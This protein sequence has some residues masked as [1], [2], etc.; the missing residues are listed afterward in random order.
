M[1]GYQRRLPVLDMRRQLAVTRASGKRRTRRQNR[2][3]GRRDRRQTD[4]LSTM[5]NGDARATDDGAARQL[6]ASRT[7]NPMEAAA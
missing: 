2:G 3:D 5:E 7:G 6:P 4:I 1:N